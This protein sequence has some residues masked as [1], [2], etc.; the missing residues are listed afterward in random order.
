[1][2]IQS[3][4]CLS[5][6][7]E[8]SGRNEEAPTFITRVGEW[9]AWTRVAWTRVV[10][11][12]VVLGLTGTVLGQASD[13]RGTDSH[14]IEVKSVL[15]KLIE[16]IEVPA[17]QAGTLM[18]MPAKE[19]NVVKLGDLL[20]RIDDAEAK[21]AV[22]RAEL[23]QQIAASKARSDYEVKAAE[24]E[25][26]VAEADLKSAKQARERLADSVSTTELDHLR[27]KV[28]LASLQVQRKNHDQ[29]VAELTE[30]QRGADLELA[31][32]HLGQRRVVAPFQGTVVEVYRHEGEWVEPGDKI[33]RLIRMDRLRAE[34]FVDARFAGLSLVDRAAMLRVDLP[35]RPGAQFPGKVT[36][37][38]PEIDPVNKQFR[39]TAEFDNREL[40]LQPG[41]RAV[42]TIAPR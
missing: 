8:L 36:F 39:V 41:L 28:A 10:W 30:Q 33:L 35:N 32:S 27:L 11:G 9:G 23:E 1:M 2:S 5:S 7:S 4:A 26:V 15:V 18:E 31:R 19:G 13:S 40:Q 22:R 20:A 38:S 42:M 3:S 14:G 29:K 6:P 12:C 17:K 34:G 37:A 24:E 25:L 21:I 16:R